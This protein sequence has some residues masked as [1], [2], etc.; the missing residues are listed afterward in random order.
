VRSVDQLVEGALQH[1]VVPAHGRACTQS[2]P[3]MHQ[4]PVTIEIAHPQPIRPNGRMPATRASAEIRDS[5]CVGGRAY[6]RVHA[7]TCALGLA[8]ICGQSPSHCS[9]QRRPDSVS[10]GVRRT[11]VPLTSMGFEIHARFNTLADVW[12]G[13]DSKAYSR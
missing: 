11:Y 10:K 7:P 5:N 13:R 9:K 6:V 4:S 8:S 12:E 1:E 2:A 3:V